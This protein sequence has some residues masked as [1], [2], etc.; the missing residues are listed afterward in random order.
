MLYRDSGMQSPL[1]SG[2]CPPGHSSLECGHSVLGPEECQLGR[3]VQLSVPA[4]HAHTPP[5]SHLA[6]A[7][8]VEKQAQAEPVKQPL[9]HVQWSSYFQK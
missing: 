7:L 4:L 8:S 6:P 9:T 2:A 3:P 5:K 1:Y